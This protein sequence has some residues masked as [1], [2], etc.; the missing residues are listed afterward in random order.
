MLKRLGE[1]VDQTA[2][3]VRATQLGLMKYKPVLLL[4]GKKNFPTRLSCLILADAFEIISD[5]KDARHLNLTD[6][7]EVRYL[8]D[9][10]Q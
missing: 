9:A 7:A 10:F 4:S 6:S 8:Y 3:V 5:P 2:G 1:L